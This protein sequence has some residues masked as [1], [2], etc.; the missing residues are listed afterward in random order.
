[1]ATRWAKR[2]VR[3]ADVWQGKTKEGPEYRRIIGAVA[4]RVRYE[5]RGVY[6]TVKLT[7][8]QRWVTRAKAVRVNPGAAA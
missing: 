4:D 6:R 1:M 8:F 2:E 7:T 5:A 3:D